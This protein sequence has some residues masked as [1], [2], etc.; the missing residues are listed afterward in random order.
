[1]AGWPQGVDEA[2]GPSPDASD[3]AIQAGQHFEV[4]ETFQDSTATPGLRQWR[5]VGEVETLELRRRG[6]AQ[7]RKGGD[8]VEIAVG[9]Q[10]GQVN[11]AGGGEMRTSHEAP[12]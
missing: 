10:G 6:E 4:D 9:Q 8:D 2:G 12:R 3:P 1:L 7:S 5:T 11:Q